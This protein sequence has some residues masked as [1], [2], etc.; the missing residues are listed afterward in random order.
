[1]R[2][3]SGF[4]LGE[5]LAILAIVGLIGS[6]CVIILMPNCHGTFHVSNRTACMTRMADIYKALYV[7]SKSN[8]SQFPRYGTPSPTGPRSAFT[9][10]VTNETATRSSRAELQRN[11]TATLWTTVK[12]GETNAN[13][14]LCPSDQ[15][16]YIDWQVDATGDPIDSWDESWDFR[17][18]VEQDGAPISFSVMDMYDPNVAHR[19]DPNVGAKWVLMADDNNSDGS[20]ST[21]GALSSTLH[22]GTR[23]LLDSGTWNQIGVEDKENSSHHV[24]E[25]QNILFGDG[26]VEFVTNPFRGPYGDNIYAVGPPNA[27]RNATN[28]SASPTHDKNDV[29]LVPVTGNVGGD[30]TLHP[31]D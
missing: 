21:P 10:N 4:G 2:R 24:Y 13:R 1:M 18:E 7:Y 5:V 28:W 3:C 14:Y 19:W 20:K 12:I 30:S 6:A 17:A 16:A 25:G 29:Y 15:D 23:P 9:G 8:A 26:H 31:Y 27:S 22:D 11:I